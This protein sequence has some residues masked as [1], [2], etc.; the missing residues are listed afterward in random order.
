METKDNLYKAGDN[1]DGLEKIREKFNYQ[2]DKVTE[3]ESELNEKNKNINTLEN[4]IEDLQNK[5][6]EIM[7][8]KNKYHDELRKIN[9][10]HNQEI[11]ELEKKLK[12]NE[13]YFDNYEEHRIK[14]QEKNLKTR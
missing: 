11:Q 7:I 13:E 8:E 2:N 3:L 14:K 5:N 10:T 4:N 9:N 12:E 1:I 6:F